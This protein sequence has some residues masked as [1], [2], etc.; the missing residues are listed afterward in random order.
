MI[1]RVGN[2]YLMLKKYMNSNK[3]FQHIF[4][5]VQ[6]IISE[7]AAVEQE[8]ITLNTPIFA[9]RRLPFSWSKLPR[10]NN[11]IYE[12]PLRLD[13]LDEIEMTLAIEKEFNIEIPEKAIYEHIHTVSSLV[14]YIIKYAQNVAF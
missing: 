13:E 14:E 10:I 6:S 12:N 1:N 9:C 3:F 7:Y 5:R 8:Q 11:N 2:V 4:Q